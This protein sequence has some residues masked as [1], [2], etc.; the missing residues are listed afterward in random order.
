MI[1]QGID[2]PVDFDWVVKYLTKNGYV[3]GSRKERYR[4]AKVLVE[5]AINEGHLSFS[6]VRADT[7]KREFITKERFELGEL[8]MRIVDE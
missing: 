8:K 6:G 1:N 5:N 2:D 7:G 4:Q 3:H